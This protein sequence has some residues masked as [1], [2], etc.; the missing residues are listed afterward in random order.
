MGGIFYSMLDNLLLF[1]ITLSLLIF[2]F[3][4]VS[5]FERE[6]YCN[7]QTYLWICQFLHIYSFCFMCF[8]GF[9]LDEQTFEL[10]C[11]PDELMALLL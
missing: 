8:K 7:L 3:L 6:N 11:P 10:V 2:Y 4:D 5:I 1:P 9:L